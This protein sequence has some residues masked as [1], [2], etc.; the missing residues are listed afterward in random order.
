M[1]TFKI[2]RK[3]ITGLRMNPN[4][5]MGVSPIIEMFRGKTSLSTLRTEISDEI[6]ELNESY[7]FIVAT[8]ASLFGPKIEGLKYLGIVKVCGRAEN[9]R[10]PPL[11]ANSSYFKTYGLVSALSHREFCL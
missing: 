10:F 3:Q 8:Y 4:L 9:Y 5:K 7:S 6:F 2:I 11:V 1:N